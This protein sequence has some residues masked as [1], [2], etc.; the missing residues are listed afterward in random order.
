MEHDTDKIHVIFLAED[1]EVESQSGV[2]LAHA[3]DK[4]EAI[5]AAKKLAGQRGIKT[6]ILHHGDGVTA[7]SRLK[8]RGHRQVS[9]KL[10][11][12]RK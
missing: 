3:N 8:N 1:W 2:P 11:L 6:V 7:P 10:L 9:S 12:D 5:D 4:C